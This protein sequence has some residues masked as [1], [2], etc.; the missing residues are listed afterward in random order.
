MLFTVQELINEIARGDLLEHKYPNVELKRNWDN[1]CGHNI[2]A[3]GNRP[4]TETS[5]LVIGVENDGKLSNHD[6]KWVIQTEKAISQNI[7]R[8]MDPSQTCLGIISQQINGSWILVIKLRYPGT[9]VLWNSKAYKAAGTTLQEMTPQ[10][11]MEHTIKQPGVTDYSKQKGSV[12]INKD[13]AK[14]FIQRLYSVR[15]DLPSADTS[16]P[17]ID[18][19]FGLIRIQ[20]TK[21]SEILFGDVPYRVI[22]YNKD[23]TIN[24]Q[25]IKYGLYNILHKKFIEEIQRYSK[26]LNNT[27]T[28]TFSEIAL[29]EGL[30]NAV[31]HAAYFEN[32]GEVIIEVYSD[33]VVISNLCLPECSY[34]ANKWFSRSHKT[35]N[36]L[37]MET[38]RLA[39]IVDELGR[40]KNLIFTDS[41]K[42]GKH[43]PVVNL[44]AAGRLN[45]WRLYIYGGIVDKLQLR[46]YNRIKDIYS[47]ESKA[48]IAYA[49]ILWRKYPVSQIRKFIDDE[50]APLFAEVLIDI[51]GPVFF[52]EKEDKLIPQRWVRILLEEGKDS[53][54]F[55]PAEEERLYNF[56]YDMQTKYQER[57]ISPKELRK[58]ADM[59]NARSEIVLSSN[60][61]KKWQT[62]GKVQKIRKGVF[63]FNQKAEELASFSKLMEMLKSKEI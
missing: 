26:E 46:L 1:D 49:L 63:K 50:S 5:W 16:N 48:L 7:N 42:K 55:T 2:S 10:E 40:G 43:P 18:G 3:L 29:K 32:N 15:D 35:V 58:L 60:I 45:R 59:A 56:A 19:I 38:L 13:L 41:I 57:L 51:D 24:K 27:S 44:E 31:A 47:N 25:E 61:L 37:L 62:E 34:F 54:T 6:E 11:M 12:D 39:K 22:Y 23:V 53:K 21:S 17:D 30:S 14:L 33:K 4:E 52:Y 8:S 28:D 9:L 20:E 36:F